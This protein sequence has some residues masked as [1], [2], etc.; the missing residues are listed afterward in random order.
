MRFAIDLAPCHVLAVPVN[1][2]TFLNHNM[3]LHVS[4][5]LGRHVLISAQFFVFIG[6]LHWVLNAPNEKLGILA[7]L[8]PSR[9]ANQE[10]DEQ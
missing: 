6:A 4:M 3:S 8:Q 5:L 2:F 1:F 7:I 10:V 9:V